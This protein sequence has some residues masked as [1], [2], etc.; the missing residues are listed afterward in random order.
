MSSFL[1]CLII[2][3]SLST[4]NL[5][6]QLVNWVN[7]ENPGKQVNSIDIR[8]FFLIPI[9]HKRATVFSSFPFFKFT[10]FSLLTAF[11]FILFKRKIKY[12]LFT[13]GAIVQSKNL[14]IYLIKLFYW[15]IY[16][17]LSNFVEI[18]LY[19]SSYYEIYKISSK[20]FVPEKLQFSLIY[21]HLSSYKYLNLSS[22][23][24]KKNISDNN[25]K[26][27]K[28]LLASRYSW[29]KGIEETIHLLSKL[30]NKDLAEL[31]I[32]IIG[33]KLDLKEKYQN[34]FPIIQFVD[35][36]LRENILYEMSQADIFMAPSKSESY[37]WTIIEALQMG[38]K[39]FVTSS[40]PWAYIK[41]NKFIH[42]V[43]PLLKNLNPKEFYLLLIQMKS[44]KRHKF[45]FKE[46]TK[47][48]EKS[49]SFWKKM[50]QKDVILKL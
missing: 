29:D 19:S 5:S 21:D 41:D 33:C 16:G 1:Y 32:K 42:L 46:I 44:L 12:I 6:D 34:L 2:N 22:L 20:I 45:R 4:R 15:Q 28:I 14:F 24:Y 9:R 36:T 40:S 23:K 39:V 27:I 7:T 31:E 26:K 50:L 13:R 17:L 11:I 25:D 10:F 30:N 37:G 38:C 35:F 49:D 47:L 43:P 3:K 8:K 18:N 48:L